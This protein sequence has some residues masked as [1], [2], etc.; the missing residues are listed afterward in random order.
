M[1]LEDR[2]RQ[3][4]EKM[5]PTALESVKK[6]QIEYKLPIGHIEVP[7]FCE[8]V[9]DKLVYSIADDEFTHIEYS[10]GIGDGLVIEG[11]SCGFY[12]DIEWKTIPLKGDRE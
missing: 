9:V 10:L 11:E 12:E 5:L 1:N 8:G 3:E 4:A 6:H 2:I 7:F